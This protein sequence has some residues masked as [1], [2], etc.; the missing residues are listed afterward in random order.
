MGKGGK[1][2]AMYLE[3]VTRWFV[4]P[5]VQAWHLAIIAVQLP[6]IPVVYVP[7]PDQPD[8]DGADQ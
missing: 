6:M 5:A 4:L 7:G 3:G 1:M 2:G 8:D